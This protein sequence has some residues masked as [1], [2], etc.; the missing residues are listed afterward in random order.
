MLLAF[1][2][3]AA[4][5]M[6]AYVIAYILGA[7][8]SAFLIAVWILAWSITIIAGFIGDYFY[9]KKVANGKAS[10]R[11]PFHH[12]WSGWQLGYAPPDDDYYKSALFYEKRSNAFL[13]IIKK[14]H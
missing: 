6:G 11:L 2:I 8:F 14:K 10:Y 5:S 3:V 12:R 9:N 7:F 4:I 1:L 13:C